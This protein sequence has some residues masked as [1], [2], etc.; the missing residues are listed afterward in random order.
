MVR[1]I[2]GGLIAAGRGASTIES[3]RIALEGGDRRAWPA[4]AE[5][6]GLTLVRVEY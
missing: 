4:P 6:R 1:S 3:L 2:V 5:A